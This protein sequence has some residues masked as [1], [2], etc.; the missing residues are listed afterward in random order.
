MVDQRAN[1]SRR[2]EGLQIEAAAELQPVSGE[3]TSGLAH[4]VVATP[5]I[6]YAQTA[7]GVKIAYWSIG[8]GA[9]LV[10]L[11]SPPLSHVYGEWSIPE[12][13]QW[14]ELLGRKRRVIRFDARE[15][16]LSDHSVPDLS[17]DARVLDIEAVVDRL[18]LDTLDLVGVAHSG[19]VAVAYAARHPGRVHR[20]V[21]CNTYATPAAYTRSPVV[22]ASRSLLDQDWR[23]YVQNLTLRSVGKCEAARFEIYVLE[24]SNRDQVRAAYASFGDFDVAAMLTEVCCP[25]LVL[26]RS[27]I[28][29]LDLGVARDLA[30]RI[31]NARLEILPGESLVPYLDDSTA[32][33]HAIERFLAEQAVPD[34]AYES[35]SSTSVILF[36][37]IA[38]STAATEE[39]GDAA[40][41]AQ[42]RQLEELLCTAINGAGGEVIDGVLLGDGVMARFPSA[43]QAIECA[44]RCTAAENAVRLKLHKGIHAGDV[45]SERRNVYGGTVNIA[46][47]LA[48]TAVPGQILVSDTV[49]ALARTSADVIFQDRGEQKL[50]GV[51]HPVRVYE[52][53]IAESL[54]QENRRLR[55]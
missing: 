31:R 49:R 23:L 50:R 29:W 54:P 15:V 19:P 51:K 17:L 28:P 12:C 35:S 30:S 5:P 33:A 14:Y 25:T 43:Q 53:R 16:G 10:H 40:F 46:A 55:E 9:A 11:S 22:D 39:I 3:T 38:E 48:E 8:Q 45:I 52:V 7:D 20:L 32:M 41:R 6:Q 44:L 36:A 26:Y 21:L 47:R 34:C 37:D 42:A 27:D 24:W 1:G 2:A 18:G 13:R 4:G